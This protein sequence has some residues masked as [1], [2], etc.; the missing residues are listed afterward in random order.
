MNPIIDSEASYALSVFGLSC[1][2]GAF[3]SVFHGFFKILR[4]AIRFNA[5][6]IAVQDFIFWFLSGLAVFMFALWQSDGIVRGYILIGVL[7]GALVYYLT[8]GEL[9]TRSAAAIAGFFRRISDKIK[10]G[11]HRKAQAAKRLRAAAKERR[12][13]E[14]TLARLKKEAKR[15]KRPKKQR[16]RCKKKKKTLEFESVDVV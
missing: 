3:L 6:A 1:L 14:R 2:L 15:A 5:V 7:I 4:I 16:K 11:L 10:N 12:K 9:I 8:I 13:H